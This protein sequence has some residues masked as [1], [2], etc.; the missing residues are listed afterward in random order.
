VFFF[1][2]LYELCELLF[3]ERDVL[4]VIILDAVYHPKAMN[5]ESCHPREELLYYPKKDL[6]I[7]FYNFLT[8]QFLLDCR[9]F[10]LKFRL[11]Y[12]SFS[13]DVIDPLFMSSLLALQ[14]LAKRKQHAK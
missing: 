6:T 9:N 14:L 12:C 5:F 10:P 13:S 3:A 8:G 4:L 7:I 2:F 11:L 1:S